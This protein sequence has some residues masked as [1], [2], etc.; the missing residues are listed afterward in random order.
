M[1]SVFT[2]SIRAQQTVHWMC[3]EWSCSGIP[4]TQKILFRSKVASFTGIMSSVVPCLD[5]S[6][7]Q[8]PVPPEAEHAAFLGRGPA[9]SPLAMGTDDAGGEKKRRR[10]TTVLARRRTRGGEDKGERCEGGS[11]WT[12]A[13]RRH[14]GR[15][16]RRLAR[17]MRLRK[18][19]VMNKN[20]YMLDLYKHQTHNISD[21][22]TYRPVTVDLL[23]MT[24]VEFALV[25]GCIVLHITGESPVMGCSATS[26]RGIVLP[27]TGESPLPVRDEFSHPYQLR[28]FTR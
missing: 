23:P 22:P 21:E 14:G 24:G 17:A 28:T 7:L 26:Q 4:S 12:Y 2:T 25:I 27:V 3:Q 20:S 11:R 5:Q 15:R 1:E 19:V 18:W 13:L 16:R 10:R 6:G 9:A 8:F